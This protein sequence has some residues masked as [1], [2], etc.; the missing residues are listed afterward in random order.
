MTTTHLYTDRSSVNTISTPRPGDEPAGHRRPAPRHGALGAARDLPRRGPA[1][2]DALAPAPRDHPQEDP[3]VKFRVDRDVLA[4]AVAWAARSLPGPS[5]RPGAGR[6]AHRGQRRR[7][8]C[9]PPSTTR[10][11]P[12]PRSPPRS[13][14]EGRALVSGRL[15]ADICRSLPGQAGRDGP[16]RRPGLADLRLGPVQPADD[17]GR[18]LPHAARRCR[19]PP[20]PC[21]SDVVRPRRRP[22]RHRRRPRRHAAG[23]DRRPHRDRRLD[24]RAAG[25]RP[26]PA[27]PPRAR[28]GTPHTPDESRRRPG[29]RP[30]CSATPPSR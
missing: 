22:G 6:P 12:A 9:S 15:L 5:E 3:H 10:P 4:D 1:W 25:H 7:A 18:G 11:R 8:W 24:D 17:A 26:V 13:A 29:A 2:Q 16:R 27:L 30:R 20:A 21:N 19:R 14:D 23:A 28:P